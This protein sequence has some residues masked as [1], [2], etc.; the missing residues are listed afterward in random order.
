MPS[1]KRE[2][3]RCD[4]W[5]EGPGPMTTMHASRLLGAKTHNL[6]DV[7][8]EV[9]PGEVL[10]LT[11]VSGSGKSSL[12][13][14]T[15]YAEGQRRF[16]ESFSPYVRQFLER[17]ERP[18]MKS[19]D[20]VAA[21]I[22]VDRR[23]PIKSSR[24]TV[25]TQADVEPYLAALFLREARP[26]CPEHREL[27]EWLDVRD[28]ASK[29]TDAAD[30]QRAVITY[31]LPVKS[32]EGYLDVR[33]RLASDGYRRLWIDGEL[34]DIDTLLPSQ[35][36][37]S[38][39]G[40]EVV[41]DR[42][43]VTS[44]A[45]SR[46]AAAIEQAWSR[47][48][49]SCRVHTSQSNQRV[50]RGL[51]CPSCG[52]HFAAANPGLFSY[53]SA[54]GACT[55]CRGFGR[56]LGFDWD[57]I[58][59]DKS[60][61]LA[62]CVIRPWRGKSTRWERA[63]LGKLCKRH[64]IPMDVAFRDLTKRHQNWVINGDGSWDEGQFP[65]VQGWFRWLETRTYKMHVRVLLSRYRAYDPC[66]DCGGQR[67]NEIALS[68]RVQG[69][70]IA[71][72][73]NL[74]IHA[75]L[76]ALG[77]LESTSGQG[78]LVRN[79]LMSRLSYLDRAGLGYLQLD[80]QAR[81]LSGGEAQRVT[82]TAAL[83]TSLHHALFVLDEP[84]VGLHPS[85][86]TPLVEMISEL[87]SRGNQVIVIEHDP[88]VIAAAD[89]IVELGPGA[90]HHGGTVVAD[91]SL[92]DFL[93]AKNATG[94][95]LAARSLAGRKNR[96][97]TTWLKVCGATAN[98]LQDVD[99]A[100]P[101]NVVCAIS[102][103]SG[104]GKSTIAI[105]IV[106]NA[107]KKRLGL[108]D[109]ELP[110]AHRELQGAD[111]ITQV[112]VV[113][114]SPLG[115]T[116]RGNPA[117]YTKAW[118]TI[119]QRL[120]AEP[121]AA[122]ANLTASSFSFNVAGGRCE[123]CSGEGSETV[124]MQFLAD[125]RLVCPEC[126]GRRFQE[127][128]CRIEHKGRSV[129]EWLGTSIGEALDLLDD[130]PAI[131]RALS[132]VNNLGLGYLQLGQPLSTLS[133]GEAQRLKLA[134][135]LSQV[136]PGT[137]LVLDEP[138]AGLHV[139]EVGYVIDALD[140]MVN[141]GASVLVVEHDLDLIAAADW[142]IDL[143]PGAGK[144]GGTVVASG[145]LPA[146]MKSGSR[147]ALALTQHRS[148]SKLRER[149]ALRADK[150]KKTK[151]TVA[152][153]GSPATFLSVEAAR[154]H[155]LKE[156]CCQ[157]PHGQL[158]VLTGPSG[159]GKSS[160]AF[161]VVFAEGQ[162]RFLQTLTPYARQFL[163]TLPRPDVDSITGVPP[164][165]A[166]EQRRA[167][168]GGS[169]TVATVTD[170]AHFARL[171]YAR[172]G[173]PHCPEH[174]LPIVAMS[175]EEL[176]PVINSQKGSFDIL[177]P[178]VRGRKGTYLDVFTNAARAGIAE[179]ICDGLWVSTDNPP[180]L[181]RSKEHEIDLALARGC[182]A[183]GVDADIIKQA[184]RWGN[185]DLKLLSKT[186][187]VTLFSTRRACPKCGFSIPELDPRWFSFATR[188]GRCETC[189]G[190]GVV[191]VTR[192]R[193][194][195]AEVFEQEC[196][197]CEGSRLSPIARAVRVLGETYPDFVKRSVAH[198][199]ERAKAYR[200]A[201]R[202]QKIA[203]PVVTELLRRLAFMNEVGLDYL[204][205]NRAAA[206]LSGG[207]MQRLR[208]AAQLG[209]GLTGALY[210][211]DEPTIGLHP[212]DTARLL[213]NLRRLVDLGSTVLVVEHDVDTIRA[214]DYLIDLGPAGGTH[215]GQLMAQGSAKSVLSHP[216]SPT[217][218]ALSGH[219]TVRSQLPIAKGH[220]WLTLKGASEHNL[221]KVDLAVPHGRMT[222][223]AGV[224]G[225]GK[226]T[227][228]RKV[229]LPALRESLG[230]ET[231]PAGVHSGLTGAT[232]IRR[233][234]AVDQSPIGRTPRSVPA[235]FLGIWDTIRSLFAASP[236]AKV[237]GFS[238]TRFSFNAAKG[239]RCPSC[240]GQGVITQEMSFLPD[241]VAPCAA[242]SGLRF[243]PQTLAIKY[244]GLS[245]GDVL[246]LT[247]E[248]AVE[249]FV[250]HPTIVAPLKTL[251]DL[252]AGYIHLGQGSHTLSGGEAQRLKLA[253]ELTATKRHE[254]TL[255]VL[256]EP[257]TGLHLAD[258]ERLMNVLSRLVERGD[259]LVV[260][261][262]HPVVIAGADYLVEL[263][264]KGGEKGGNIVAQGTPREV[265]KKKT[266]TASVLQ[267]WLR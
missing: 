185:G 2:L 58:M 173:I 262:H 213:H 163:P 117:T 90:G 77:D 159:S 148:Q 116:S 164:A 57:K 7:D 189:E 20:P 35:A 138:S 143:G 39:T 187:K 131:V 226:S 33:E 31:P 73:H 27:A 211:L 124:E 71:D 70:S 79:E 44:K 162:R 34:S 249:A 25:A 120:A 128:V 214:A 181:A 238:A 98:N 210:V 22:A 18:P 260:I 170:V 212:T 240:E 231:E 200:F 28:A 67:L 221:K 26:L 171:L 119:R 80:R 258:V 123:A 247:L 232:G 74:E 152:A 178:V 252:G 97:P 242:C 17:L 136:N 180:K 134:R 96:V 199:H 127:Q 48:Q 118:D 122:A 51:T 197:A 87:G 83:G 220:A 45:Q 38:S 251:C 236:D 215:G 104:S 69:R 225:S 140:R 246:E 36:M 82:L 92:K 84:T 106:A 133:G 144:A 76:Q 153:K 169:S 72:W 42:I 63:E 261:E 190:R 248:Q 55:T 158:T 110:G 259:T 219:P 168:A 75:A 130:V 16:I 105:E 179:A 198:A 49:G 50:D 209:A 100:L 112:V 29:V 40:L 245:I 12:A 191:E 99:V 257:T 137:L 54:A 192:G 233:A 23:A 111:A 208:L 32:V 183:S 256:D 121:A 65:G 5:F 114:Q 223:V 56:I 10:V 147:T 267:E 60:L 93:G 61:S 222:V 243:E 264:P 68:Y 1:A 193:G 146:V 21:G 201:G 103:P 237:A 230:L 203:G 176:L 196:S 95:A 64:S 81:T 206:T 266:P 235:T 227:L 13:I 182:R 15:L 102:G 78:A 195:S 89:R 188:Q 263:G 52:R 241:V 154:E 175:V 101:L 24:S 174:D 207:E 157:I 47:S 41:I 91:G 167:R 239:G 142:I 184:L 265:S 107:I 37:S 216:Q 161:D 194:K 129:A 109:A 155:N 4:D 30:G 113:D 254:K 125:V 8:L 165:I 19:L 62:D 253:T 244:L 135:A 156:V 85:D 6:R 11:G 59:P 204:S 228:V 53:E 145:T 9:R 132:P 46:L 205:L 88:Q 166:L 115:R 151:R 177:A 139:D 172:V 234:L 218:K 229:M 255:Y 126:G 186:G 250:H 14:E 66:P 149:L 86:I 94:R 43:D 108:S 150:D 217:A 3:G 141:A 224:S 202:D 160:L